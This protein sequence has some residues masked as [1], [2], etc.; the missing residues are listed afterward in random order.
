MT[1]Q[2]EK[3]KLTHYQMTSEV[4]SNESLPIKSRPN[5]GRLSKQIS[6]T[7]SAIYLV[8]VN[9]KLCV[10]LGAT[11]LFAVIVMW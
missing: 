6:S 11:P 2:L 8:T 3:F 7:K 9:V 10:L 5:F 1:P 4:N